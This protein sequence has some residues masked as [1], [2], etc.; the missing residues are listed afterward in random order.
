MTIGTEHEYSIND[1]DFRPLPIN[2]VLI[3]ELNGE[4]VNE[5]QFGEVNLSKELQKNVIEIVPTLPGTSVQG[6]ERTLYGGLERL[7]QAT[8]DRYRFLGLGM[9]PLLKLDQTSVWDHE[10]KEIYEVYDRLFDIRQHG[11]LNIQAIQI[12]VPF[13][14]D[15]EMVRLF[16]R[17][18]A[19][20]PYLVAIGASSPYVEGRLTGSEDNRLIFYRDNQR[21][22]PIIAH[23]VIPEML[24]SKQDYLDIQQEMYRELRKHDAEMLCHEWVDSRGVIVRFSRNCVEIKAIDEQECLHSD[25]AITAL[26]LALLRSKDFHLTEDDEDLRSLTEAAIKSGTGQ[27]RQ[28]LRQVLAIASKSANQDERPYLGLIEERIEN[29]SLAELMRA[30]ADEGIRATLEDMAECLRT[31]LPYHG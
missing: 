7:Y 10:D 23:G 24:R 15:E 29:G 30:R 18:R 16:N 5:F 1:R 11:W 9:H 25:M 19:I 20:I 27:L 4:V 12:N 14:N 21:R 26:S 13:T 2:D 31:N 6:L 17:T 28:E 3:E 22:M 8:Q